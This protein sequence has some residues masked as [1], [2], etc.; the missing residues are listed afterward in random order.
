MSFL[1][2]HIK[3]YNI[4]SRLHKYL[5]SSTISAILLTH[6]MA[7]IPKCLNPLK[8]VVYRGK[9]TKQN[10]KPTEQNKK[11]IDVQIFTDLIVVKRHLA[12]S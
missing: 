5:D 6:T 4:Q 10:K 11:H 2:F 9:N 1:S 3:R 12:M 7:L 8:L